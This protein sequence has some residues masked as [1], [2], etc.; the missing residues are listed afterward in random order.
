MPSFAMHYA[1][2]K[3]YCKKNNQS[4]CMDFFSGSLMPDLMQD[5]N[6]THYVTPPKGQSIEEIIKSKIGIAEYVKNNTVDNDFSRGEFLHLLTDYAFGEFALK[7]KIYEKA[8]IT[9][10]DQ[11]IKVIRNEYKRLNSFLLENYNIDS[12]Q[13]PESENDISSELP[14][15]LKAEEVLKFIDFCADIDLSVTYKQIKNCIKKKQKV[16]IWKG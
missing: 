11:V 14:E 7:N 15:I 12:T 5:K 6:R 4:N 1:I 3:E 2:A 10:Y 13:L 8:N 9:T 16:K